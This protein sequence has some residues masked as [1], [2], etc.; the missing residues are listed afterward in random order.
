[1]DG[2]LF[3]VDSWGQE[4]SGSNPTFFFF[5]FGI[6]S[7]KLTTIHDSKDFQHQNNNQ[8]T[9]LTQACNKLPRGKTQTKLPKRI[10][11]S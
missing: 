6:S 1:M 3:V 4:V 8:Y 10:Q 7:C 11:I 5:S 9:G 2:S